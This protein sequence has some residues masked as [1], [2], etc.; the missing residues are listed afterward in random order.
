MAD[1]LIILVKVFRVSQFT[2][3]RSFK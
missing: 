3:T 2:I 1:V